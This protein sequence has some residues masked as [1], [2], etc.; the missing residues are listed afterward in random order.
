MY[1]ISFR[2]IN[3]LFSSDARY[4][5][6]QEEFFLNVPASACMISKHLVDSIAS[7]DATEFHYEIT[8]METLK[9]NRGKCNK[10]CSR[11]DW[12]DD[13]IAL[14]T[15]KTSERSI[16]IPNICENFSPSFVQEFHAAPLLIYIWQILLPRTIYRRSFA[17]G[18][19]GCFMIAL[20]ICFKWSRHFLIHIHRWLVSYQS[21]R[22]FSS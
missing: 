20:T 18:I 22:Q 14:N 13:V 17:A 2:K 10:Y 7:L 5:K 9:W 3:R 4:R 21:L 15:H 19:H 16:K 1:I 8:L 12:N 11:Y 6:L